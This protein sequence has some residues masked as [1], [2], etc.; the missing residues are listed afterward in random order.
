MLLAANQEPAAL[1][2]YEIFLKA[3]G[4]NPGVLNNIAWLLRDKNPTR[5]LA[6]AS[7][8][9]QLAPNSADIADTLGYLMLK[10]NDAKK[11]LPMLQRAHNLGPKNGQIAYHLALAYNSLGRKTEAKQAL[12]DALAKGGNFADA[13]DARKL[14]QKL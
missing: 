1:A 12:K 5:A 2:Q 4:D 8:A 9:A 11:A 6:M 7:K 14:L 3:R 13:D 10:K